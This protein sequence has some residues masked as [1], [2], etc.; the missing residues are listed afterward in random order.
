MPVYIVLPLLLFPIIAIYMLSYVLNNK[1][2]APEGVTQISKCST[3]N[4]GSCPLA[5]TNTKEPIET[6]EI[7]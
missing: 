6:C 1:T 3:C 5:G 4:S 7:K 2:K